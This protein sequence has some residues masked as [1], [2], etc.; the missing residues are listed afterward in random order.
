MIPQILKPSTTHIGKAYETQCLQFLNHQL[1][2]SL[3]Q[4]G[5]KGDG[6]IDLRGWWWLPPNTPDDN[7]K[8][9]RVLVQ[10]KAETKKPGP[11][12]IREM[13][14]TVRRSMDENTSTIDRR[15]DLKP[16]IAILCSRSGFTRGAI[17]SVLSSPIPMMAL[18]I[19]NLPNTSIPESYLAGAVW[20]QGLLSSQGIFQGR[21]E[22]RK[23]YSDRFKR[24]S[25]SDMEIEKSSLIEPCSP[26]HVDAWWDG[27][28]LK[29]S[30][31]D[32]E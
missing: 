24:P 8:R 18:H 14:G 23:T 17:H 25:L 5:G 32:F 2:M 10:C 28:L 15:S 7:S 29:R 21:M 9:I 31:P 1:F 3:S 26:F 11:Q 22:L 20:N 27:K 30:V 6:G 12:L 16:F 19:P 4:V 13:E